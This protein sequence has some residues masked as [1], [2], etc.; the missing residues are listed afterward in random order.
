MHELESGPVGELGRRLEG[1]GGVWGGGGGGREWVGAKGRL[2]GVHSNRDD[3]AEL[4]AELE[5][6]HQKR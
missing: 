5:C 1:E 6:L 2:L 3:V 4:V